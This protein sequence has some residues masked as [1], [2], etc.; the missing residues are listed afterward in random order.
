ML[1]LEAVDKIINTVAFGWNVVAVAVPT[2]ALRLIR[3][4]LARSFRVEQWHPDK[5]KWQ[6]VSS[7]QGDEAWES[8]GP[9]L[10]D[11]ITKQA[12]VKEM[13]KLAQHQAKMAANKAQGDIR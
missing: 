9:S 6:V 4:D 12:R 13:I 1:T 11:M 2:R 10:G 8:L 5:N 7:H 3:D